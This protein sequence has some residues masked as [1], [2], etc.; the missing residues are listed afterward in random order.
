MTRRPIDLY[1]LI[2]VVGANSRGT[3]SRQV[4]EIQVWMSFS[5][6]WTRKLTQHETCSLCQHFDT[7]V[8][9]PF[10]ECNLHPP[11]FYLYNGKEAD[12]ERGDEERGTGGA[13]W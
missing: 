1:F 13:S 6:A 11:L 2:R 9:V 7:L 10:V 4:P 12:W 3:N 8:S 5:R